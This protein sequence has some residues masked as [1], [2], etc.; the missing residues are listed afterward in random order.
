[1][2]RCSLGA[3]V[4]GCRGETETLDKMELRVKWDHSYIHS[5]SLWLDVKILVKTLSVVWK[6]EQAY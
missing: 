4:N 3:Q 1:M 6:Q 2:G 5:W